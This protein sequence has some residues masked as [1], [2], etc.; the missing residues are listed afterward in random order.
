MERHGAWMQQETK[1]IFQPAPGFVVGLEER[2]IGWC[3][4]DLPDWLDRHSL[5]TIAVYRYTV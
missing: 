3:E 2:S 1:V 5:S 4:H